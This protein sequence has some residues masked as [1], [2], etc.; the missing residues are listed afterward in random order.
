MAHDLT[1]ARSSAYHLA[2]S[3]MVCVTLFVTDGGYGVMPSDEFDG[4]PAS[5]IHEFDPHGE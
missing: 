3:L 5:V 1:L 2:Q 4:D